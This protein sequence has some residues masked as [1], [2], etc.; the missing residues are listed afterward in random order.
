MQKDN[1]FFNREVDTRV[2]PNPTIAEAL[3]EIHFD[4]NVS[5]NFDN[6][7]FL[8][9]L[10]EEL[11]SDYPS[12]TEQKIKQ[13]HASITDMGISINEEKDNRTR[14][15]FKHKE[16]NH[17]LQ[18]HSN[19]LTINEVGKYFGWDVFLQ[20]IYRGW[21][22]INQ[23]LSPMSV[24][25]IGLRYIN[26]IPRKD[27][28]EPLSAWLKPC[29]YYPHAILDN[30]TGF[31]SRNEFELENN[32]RLIVT[33]SEPNV[34]DKKGG[35]VFDI[36]VISTISNCNADLK[37]IYEHLENLHNIAW[38]VFS[39]SLSPKYEALLSGEFL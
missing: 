24:K 35:I 33:I 28:N 37:V 6:D 23:K 18:L 15:I 16:R 5:Q 3:C 30:N 25:R 10:K 11:I 20:D 1:I 9:F 26:L 7:S 22:A 2:Y 31:L 34:K 39:S 13:Y 14:L 29:K 12:V 19:I 8:K 36:D 32:C 4:G 27:I 38:I 21:N 17:L